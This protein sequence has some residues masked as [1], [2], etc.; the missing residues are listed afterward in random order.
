MLINRNPSRLL[1]NYFTLI[2]IPVHL[3][4]YPAGCAD[5]DSSQQPPE[6]SNVETTATWPT[7]F[8]KFMAFAN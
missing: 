2:G 8:L 4:N 3:C 1:G 6:Q 7:Y 5:M